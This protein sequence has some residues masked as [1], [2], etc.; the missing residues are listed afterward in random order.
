ME[1]TGG[2][3][4]AA[5]EVDRRRANEHGSRLRTQRR[6]PARGVRRVRHLW[7]PRRRRPD[8][9]RPPRAAAPRPG[10]GG[11]RRP[12]TASSFQT[13]A[14]GSASS[15]TTS[16]SEKV[17]DR[18]A[19]AIR[20]WA[21]CA[22]RPRGEHH[23]AQRAAALRR[24]RRAAASRSAHNGNLTNGLTLRRELVAQR[25][26]LPVD[27]RHRGDPASRGALAEEPH[28]RRA[29]ST[30]CAQLEGAYA[31]VALTKQEADRRA[32]PARHP[33]AGPR[34]ARRRLRSCASE[35]CALD[36]IGA[37]YVREIENG[38]VGR[39]LGRW[40]SRSLKPFPSRRH[41]LCMFEYVYFSRPD[42]MLGGRSVYEVRKAHGPRTRPRKRQSRPTWSCRCPTA[43]F[44]PHSAMRRRRGIPFELGI[45]RNH[46]VGRTF[47]EPTATIRSLGVKLKHNANRAVVK[48]KR[49]VLI[50]D[51]IV[52]GT[53]SMKIVADGP[54][55][56]CQA[57]VHMRISSPP[58]T[59]PVTSTASTRRS[60][61]RCSGRH[62]HAG[63]DAPVLIGVDSLAF[64]SV[65]GV[66]RA[67]G[68]RAATTRR[69]AVHRP[70]LH[71]RLS[72]PPDRPRRRNQE[73]AARCSAEAG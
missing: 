26:D 73:A 22:I 59:A 56:R 65:D 50:D 33:P 29:A 5:R 21:T 45:I 1:S 14:R 28:R 49:V 3:D 11:H 44:P 60:R 24:T 31:L 41:G 57:E 30:R 34:Q 12:S 15:A 25:R 58:I 17:I 66:Y 61:S 68:C 35:T 67:V 36:I 64:L 46:Y 62:P 7:P 53:T 8:G 18:P 2:N 13:A 39:D 48:G 38:E 27:V 20:R 23:P 54:P 47:I 40:A 42:S 70:L 69:A 19:R 63:G 4:Q 55:G 32:R 52:R 43:A 9:P 16:S 37:N 72:H 10:G 71:R 51:S 6:P